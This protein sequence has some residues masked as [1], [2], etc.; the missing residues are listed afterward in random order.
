MGW[1]L[2]ALQGLG[3]ALKQGPLPLQVHPSGTRALL[4]KG[5]RLMRSRAGVR[6]VPGVGV[7]ALESRTEPGAVC[8]QPRRAPAPPGAGWEVRPDGNIMG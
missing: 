8:T 6:G 7:R 4:G 1:T 5:Q 2:R 3:G